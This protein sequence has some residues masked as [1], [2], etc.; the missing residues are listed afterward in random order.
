MRFKRTIALKDDLL[1]E[2]CLAVTG[3]WLGHSSGAFALDISDLEKM[4]INFDKRKT[5]VVIDYEHQSLSGNEAPAAG[6][7]K[8][9]F[10][11]DNELWG[12]VEW[13]KKAKE[14][15]KNKE[16]KYLSPVYEFYSADEK[17]GSIKGVTL[18]SASLT[19][20]PFLDELGEIVANKSNTKDEKMDKDKE[21]TAL[22]AKISELESKNTSLEQ[23]NREFESSQ[24]ALKDSIANKTVENAIIANKISSTQK[25]WALKYAKSD[26]DGFNEFLNTAKVLEAPQNNLFANKAEKSK[27]DSFDPVK[28]ATNYING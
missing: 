14:Y 13:T 28:I 27:D 1:S 22:K 3:E 21:I 25:E 2:I 19:N 15:I 9:L 24:I 11:K 23:K 26:I 8:E 20:T 7:V 5:D 12:R 17:T 16:Y 6:W 4:K 10:L 18:H